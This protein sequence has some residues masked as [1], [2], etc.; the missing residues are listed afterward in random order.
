LAELLG[1]SLTVASE[2]GA[3]STF[4][5][6]IPTMYRSASSFEPKFEWNPD[7]SRLPLLVIEDAP[8]DQFFYEKIFRTSSFQLYP[9]YTGE[10]AEEALRVC[11]PVAVILDLVLGGEEAWELL[12]R[13]K[14]DE[15]SRNVPVIIVS[16]LAH[17]EKGLALG[18]DAYMVKPVDRRALI[19]TINGL[20][21]RTRSAVRVLTIDDEEMARYLIRQCLPVPAFEVTEAASAEE[22]LQR[23]R[24]DRPD[25]IV[26]DLIMPG[27]DGRGALAEL[28]QD[29]MTRD[30]PVVI[31]TGAELKDDEA[32]RLLQQA[33]AILPK[34]NL[35][36]A[37]LPGIVRQALGRTV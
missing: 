32:R 19:D 11:D 36:R 26:L 30:I 4:S 20:Q 9:A 1:G 3:G 25:V 5:L 10:Q 14:R 21:A 29:P 6:T 37:T 17:Q 18:A 34:R 31:S 7:P 8:D 24:A 23:A 13:L 22:G 35:S 2:P 28:R 12:L 33:A 16:A 27:L 15:R